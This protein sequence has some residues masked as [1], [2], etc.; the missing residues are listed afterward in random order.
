MGCL[1]GHLFSCF[2]GCGRGLECLLDDLDPR[3]FRGMQRRRRHGEGEEQ[4]DELGRSH[5]ELEDDAMALCLIFCV[6]LDA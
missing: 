6:V 1:V 5:V 4:G 3:R 2:L